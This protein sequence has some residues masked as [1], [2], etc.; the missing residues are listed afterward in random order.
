MVS[1]I[2]VTLPLEVEGLFRE[3]KKDTKDDTLELD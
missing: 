1:H 3:S 2:P